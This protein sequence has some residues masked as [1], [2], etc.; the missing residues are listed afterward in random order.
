[1]CVCITEQHK[2]SAV[3]I[4]LPT[5]TP[6]VP[7][8]LPH[9]TPP[10]QMD[11][12]TLMQQIF[13]RDMCIV[14]STNAAHCERPMCSEQCGTDGSTN[15]GIGA[16]DA[17]E[18]DGVGPYRGHS[19]GHWGPGLLLVVLRL[20]GGRAD[21][22]VRF[23]ALKQGLGLLNSARAVPEITILHLTFTSFNR[24]CSELQKNIENRISN[25]KIYKN[26]STVCYII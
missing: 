6:P 22:D 19:R 10:R 2:K 1:M 11:Y 18:A 13:V 9:P 17:V 21:G 15:L 4:K 26:I 12:N 16:V 20:G 5:V 14:N 8:S 7:P 3:Q 24:S 23:V 25:L